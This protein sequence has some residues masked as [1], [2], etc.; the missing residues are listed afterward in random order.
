MKNFVTPDALNRVRSGI[1]SSLR[2]RYDFYG[3]CDT[4]LT[5]GIGALHG[6][7]GDGT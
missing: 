4:A 2:Q 1:I 7:C 3:V 5:P 6:F